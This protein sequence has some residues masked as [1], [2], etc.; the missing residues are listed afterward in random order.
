MLLGTFLYMPFGEPMHGFILHA[1][2]EQE[3]L[4]MEY[5]YVQH[6]RYR[7]TFSTSVTPVHTLGSLGELQL[8]RVVGNNGYFLWFLI[9]AILWHVL[10]HLYGS[11]V[12][13]PD[14]Y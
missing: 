11:N 1:Y 4:V 3:L 6:I 8:F 5:M 13:F 7:Q 14:Y 9:V 10:L 12:L 2:L